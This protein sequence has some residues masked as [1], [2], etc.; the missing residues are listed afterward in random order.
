M[1][2]PAV[3]QP[4]QQSRA[5]TFSKLRSEEILRQANVRFIEELQINKM[6][7]R[8]KQQKKPSSQRRN[9]E[10]LVKQLWR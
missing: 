4:Q 5:G 2:G 1:S 3:Q 8:F 9:R 10:A 7:F 6:K